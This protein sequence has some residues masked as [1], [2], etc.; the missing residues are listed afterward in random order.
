[1]PGSPASSRNND[2]TDQPQA[3]SVP[4]EMSVSMVAVACF[5]LSHAARWKGQPPQS[6]TGVAS[7]SESHC[8]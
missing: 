5:R 4:T 7:C 6:T 8:Q 1:M 3:E 2:T